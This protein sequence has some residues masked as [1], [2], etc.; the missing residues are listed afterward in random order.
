[1]PLFSNEAAV[2]LDVEQGARPYVFSFKRFVPEV[3]FAV[4]SRDSA[5]FCHIPERPRL[6]FLR[7]L[8]MNR[9]RI[10]RDDAEHLPEDEK[11]SIARDVESLLDQSECYSL[12]SVGKLHLLHPNPVSISDDVVVI[13]NRHFDFLTIHSPSEENRIRGSR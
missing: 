2:L 4:W 6:K 3:D 8:A 9:S 10:V 7:S 12:G 1:M 13:F 5:R 11:H